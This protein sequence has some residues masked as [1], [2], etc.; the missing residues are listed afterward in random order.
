M[1][2]GTFSTGRSKPR[3]EY[4]LTDHRWFDV[5]SLQQDWTV[6]LSSHALLRVGAEAKP[7]S[8]GF[9]YLSFGEAFANG[10]RSNHQY[11]RM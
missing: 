9:D 5:A 2:R 4:Q 1:G 7:Q 8:A 11:H 10:S 3:A 6:S